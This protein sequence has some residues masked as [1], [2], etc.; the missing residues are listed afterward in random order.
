M[1]IIITENQFD[2]LI[3]NRNI[4]INESLQDEID[5]LIGYGFELV[6]RCDVGTYVMLLLKGEGYYQI[7]LTTGDEEFTTFDSQK[8]R[9]TT[10]SKIVMM[11]KKLINTVKNWLDT[12][13]DIMVG[14]FNKKR[15]LAYWRIFN[16]YG[17][18][19]SDIENSPSVEY[20]PESSNF[21]IYS[22]SSN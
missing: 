16:N 11:S 6:D 5:K 9:P 18:V 14:S 3:F 2:F 7:A 8:K 13:G 17:F 15:T 12:Y 20:F 22:N 4:Q 19:T 1:K 10:Q 21:V